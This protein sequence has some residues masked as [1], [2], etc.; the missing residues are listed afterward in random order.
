[1]LVFLLLL[2]VTAVA[3]IA[4]AVALTMTDGY[5]RIPQRSFLRTV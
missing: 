2:A 1:M 4:G 5:G 3:A